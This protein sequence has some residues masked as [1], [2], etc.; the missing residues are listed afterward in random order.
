MA[1]AKLQSLSS[2]APLTVIERPACPKCQGQMML[3]R[4]MPTFLGAD[5]HTF[6]CFVCNYV[7]QTLGAYDDSMQSRNAGAT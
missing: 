2:I 5:L 6:E 1:M 3:A 7:L 4:I